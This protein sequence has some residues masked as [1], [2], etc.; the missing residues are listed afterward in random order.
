M[1]VPGLV[2]FSEVIPFYWAIPISL[3]LIGLAMLIAWFGKALKSLRKWS[4]NVKGGFQGY[5][6]VRRSEREAEGVWWYFSQFTHVI[7][8][9]FVLYGAYI[10][11]NYLLTSPPDT[12]IYEDILGPEGIV[13]PVVTLIVIYFVLRTAP[14]IV[15]SVGGDEVL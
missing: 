2:D 8:I 1:E 4:K 12:T 6:D 15:R 3:G 13:I 14:Y 7:L 10:I 11:F 5:F 9:G